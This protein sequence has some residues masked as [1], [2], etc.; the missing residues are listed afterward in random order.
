MATEVN[1]QSGAQG[2][3]FAALFEESIEK[4]SF[5]REGEIIAGTIVQVDRDMVVVDI[6]GKSEG[7]IPLKEFG[8]TTPAGPPVN[9][10]DRVDVFVES[11]ETD[12]GLLKISKLDRVLQ[13]KPDRDAA[14]KV[15]K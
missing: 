10:G 15:F 12:D 6:G 4:D 2:N 1:H 9:V 3:S 14:L 5:A 8:D 13:I 7:V 11:R